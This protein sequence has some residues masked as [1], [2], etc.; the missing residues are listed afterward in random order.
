[1]LNIFSIR[2]DSQFLSSLLIPL[3]EQGIYGRSQVFGCHSVARFAQVDAVGSDDLGDQSGMKPEFGDEPFME[4]AEGETEFGGQRTRL[5]A[6]IPVHVFVQSAPR[7]K[8]L[9]PNVMAILKGRARDQKDG[10]L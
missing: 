8:I 4:I 3:G 6:Y 1:M 9:S 7:N 5:R 2:N 10:C